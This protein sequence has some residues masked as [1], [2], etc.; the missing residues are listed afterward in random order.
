MPWMETDARKQRQQFYRDYVS[1]Q[2][3]MIELCERYEIS[4]P[5]TLS[6]ARRSD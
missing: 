1:G 2:W 4:R 5:T 3:S 6:K